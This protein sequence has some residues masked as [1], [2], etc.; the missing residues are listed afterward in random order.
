MENHLKIGAEIIE[1]CPCLLS[2]S[3]EVSAYFRWSVLE[4]LSSPPLL[5][6]ISSKARWKQTLRCD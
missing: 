3:N 6:G 5:T 2:H 4:P 1:M